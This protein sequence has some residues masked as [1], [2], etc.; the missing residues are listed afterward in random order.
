MVRLK[1]NTNLN[2]LITGLGHVGWC[3]LL[4]DNTIELS[5]VAILMPAHLD[6]HVHWVKDHA[7]VVLIIKVSKIQ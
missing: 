4:A 5:P 7:G 2:L 6:L 3:E 1:M